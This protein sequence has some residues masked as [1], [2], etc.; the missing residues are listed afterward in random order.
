MKQILKKGFVAIILLLSLQS[1][2]DNEAERVFN[3][4]PSVRLEEQSKE[5]QELLK[6]STEGWKTTYFTDD[7]QLGGFTFLFKFTDNKNVEMASDFGDDDTVTASEWD[8]T[9]GSTVKLTFTTKNKIH[10]L[11]DSNNYPDGELRG[12]GY[13][14]SFEFLYYGVDGDDIIF[15]SNRDFI[16]VRFTK[17]TPNDWVDLVKNRDN[18][19]YIKDNPTKSVFRT[20]NIGDKVYNFSYDVNRRFA[21]N[22]NESTSIDFGVGFTSTG[23]TISPALDINGDKVSEFTYD[24]TTDRFVASLN[25]TEVASIEYS[26]A[27]A[28]PL[29]GYTKLGDYLN[30]NYLR[31]LPPDLD[32][33]AFKDY[34]ADYQT[35]Y[36]FLNLSQVVVLDMDKDSGNV[37]FVTG[38]GNI[39][40]GFDK[41]ISNDKVYLTRNQPP[42]PNDPIFQPLLD[43]FF[44]AEGLYIEQPGTLDG[45]TNLTF[46]F[47]PASNTSLKYS[48]F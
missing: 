35:N 45:Y 39:F 42:T 19:L 5:L 27:P 41:T 36:A 9:I 3:E 48:F 46:T 11:S 14:G 23:I 4:V 12:Q 15:R 10:D 29:T 17:A 38:F 25:A 8:V 24:V 37:V 13:K 28:F 47:V 34:M 31:N 32:N 26:N 33:Q 22:V 21:K 30:L 16:E 20:L 44:D 6:S 7:S 43:L 18:M 1:C 2:N 40:Y